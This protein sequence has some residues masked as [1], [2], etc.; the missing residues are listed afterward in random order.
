MSAE[1]KTAD[2]AAATGACYRLIYR[3]HSLLRAHCKDDQA[4]AEILK[5]ARARNAERGITGALMLYDDWFAQVLEG[6]QAAVETLYARIKA[7]PRHDAIRLAEAGPV[8]KRLFEKWAMA[9]V[10][11]HHQPDTPMVATTGGL[12][13]GAPWRISLEQEAI[14]TRLRDM[15]RGYGRSS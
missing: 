4:L 5:V 10:A 15:T 14:L 7:D 9:L 12:A 6:P 2:P 3:S 13:Q 11:E 8:A 1:T